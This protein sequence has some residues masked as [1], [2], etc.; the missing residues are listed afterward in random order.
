MIETTIGT[1][2]NSPFCALLAP[3]RQ[4]DKDQDKDR[5]NDQSKSNYFVKS[6]SQANGGGEPRRASRRSVPPPG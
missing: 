3:A 5:D 1:K 6:S 4:N 2:I